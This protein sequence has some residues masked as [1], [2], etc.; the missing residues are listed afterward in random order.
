MHTICILVKK[1]VF[2][3]HVTIYE[4]YKILS[5]EDEMGGACGAHGGD[6]GCIHHF[7]WEA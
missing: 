7:G 3:D 6:E 2:T 5:K 1:I 4:T